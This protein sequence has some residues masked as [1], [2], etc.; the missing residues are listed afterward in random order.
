M[1]KIFLPAIAFSSVLLATGSLSTV[2]QAKT[3][4]GDSIIST[5]P[6]Y[7]TQSTSLSIAALEQKTLVQINQYRA[8]RGL[9][10][11]TSNATIR[12]QAR[13]HSQNMA[14]GTVP[15][16]H[17]GFQQRLQA[18]ARVIP[19]M[20]M[21]ENV[22]YNSG[23]SDPVTTAVQ[24]WLKSPGHKVNIEGNYNLTGIGVAKSRTGAYYFTQIFLRRR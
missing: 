5:T 10:P 21:A 7:L 18:I 2:A 16:G 13:L 15:F 22:A 12:Q 3:R 20:A 23:Y 19:L 24:G 11:L 6:I 17:Q 1:N 14:N 4:M 8:G 9:P